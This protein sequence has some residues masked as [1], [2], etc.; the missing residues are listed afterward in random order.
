MLSGSLS[1]EH[2]LDDVVRGLECRN[3]WPGSA[4]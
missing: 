3:W 4:A 2:A 1:C